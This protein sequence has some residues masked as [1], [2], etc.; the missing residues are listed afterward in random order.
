VAT[1]VVFPLFLV[2]GF[3]QL[4]RAD[5]KRQAFETSRERSGLAPVNLNRETSLREQGDAMLWRRVV[6]AGQ[7]VG[8]STF[9]H[10]NQVLNGIAG[11]QVFSPFEIDETDIWIMINRGWIAAGDY[12]DRLPDVAVPQGQVV[13]DGTVHP[14]PAV[15]MLLG[16]A[17]AEDMGGGARRLQ[18]MEQGMLEEILKHGLLPY[19]IRLTPASPS[20]FVREWQEPDPGI[21]RHQGYAFQWFAL[22]AA[23]A[24]AFVSVNIRRRA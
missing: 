3:W 11:Y 20:G 17:H 13:L 19:T 15:V 16:D 8:D 12:R 6:V 5:Q 23:V 7:Y 9:L 21:A 10:D 24:I 1:L 22:A 4:D 14:L 18:N 2:L